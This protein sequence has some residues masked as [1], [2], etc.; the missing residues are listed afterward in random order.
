MLTMRMK[1]LKDFVRAVL[2]FY[3]GGIAN[4]YIVQ[5]K[6]YECDWEDLQVDLHQLLTSC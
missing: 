6:N 5:G 2:G 1:R 3:G 4:S